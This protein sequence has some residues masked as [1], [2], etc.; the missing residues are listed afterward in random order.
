MYVT[1]HKNQTDISFFQGGQL[2]SNA[3][4]SI[5]WSQ[6]EGQEEIEIWWSSMEVVGVGKKSFQILMA[7]V[8]PRRTDMKRPCQYFWHKFTRLG[9]KY[10]PAMVVTCAFVLQASITVTR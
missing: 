10:I 1:F 6:W 8:T 9:K 4:E 5:F 7:T 2:E 3:C